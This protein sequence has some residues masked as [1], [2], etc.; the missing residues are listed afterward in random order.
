MK[1]RMFVLSSFVLVVVLLGASHIHPMLA[2]APSISPAPAPDHLVFSFKIPSLDVTHDSDGLAW[3]S[4]EGFDVSSTPGDPVLP[5]KAYHIALPTD[6]VWESVKVEVVQAEMTELAGMY[7]I[8]PAPPGT[9]WEEDHQIILWGK[10][11]DTIVEG[12]NAQVYQND[13]YFPPSLLS[14]AGHDQMRK[15][16][17]LNLIATPVQYNP[18]TGKLRQ[19]TEIQIQVTFDRGRVAIAA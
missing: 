14:V 17:V 16:R 11:D 13:A 2:Q 3:L 19:A 15:W 8:A 18:V 4:I 1:P 10:N 12:K 5:I 7:T 6:V 9:T